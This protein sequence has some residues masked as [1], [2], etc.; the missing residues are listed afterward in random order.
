M[1]TKFRDMAS[2]GTRKEKWDI[3]YIES[4]NEDESIQIFKNKFGLDPFNVTCSCCGEDYSLTNDDTLE[5]VT[6]YERNC[7]YDRNINSYIEEQG[8]GYQPYIPLKLYMLLDS[9]LFIPKG[10]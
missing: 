5:L 10:E 8:N 3:I 7:R 6:A 9:V 4:D 1:W 2:G